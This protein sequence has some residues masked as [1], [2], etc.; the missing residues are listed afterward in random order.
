MCVESRSFP[1]AE[2]DKIIR[3][4]AG[5]KRPYEDDQRGV[6]DRE[7]KV[8]SEGERVDCKGCPI[9]QSA[10][11]NQ[12]LESIQRNTALLEECGRK[13]KLAQTQIN[14]QREQADKACLHNW[15]ESSE[16]SPQLEFSL[17]KCAVCGARRIAPPWRILAAAS[18]KEKGQADQVGTGPRKTLPAKG[19]R[20]K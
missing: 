15:K 19:G 3:H 18:E 1:R 6:C 14:F 10:E 12:S 5:E 8:L 2:V 17:Q 11:F 7:G 13:A 16:K 4:T 9:C 20:K